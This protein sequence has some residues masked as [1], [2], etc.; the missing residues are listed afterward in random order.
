[1]MSRQ[2]ISCT[3]KISCPIIANSSFTHGKWL[4][5][6]LWCWRQ[7]QF[8]Y[9]L[10]YDY[11]RGGGVQGYC[12]MLYFGPHGSACVLQSSIV[13]HLAY[14]VLDTSLLFVLSI[15]LYNFLQSMVLSWISHMS[16]TFWQIPTQSE[17][18]PSVHHYF[19]IF[20]FHTFWLN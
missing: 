15:V 1:M 8:I 10:M 13:L 2:I 12:G 18:L 6:G 7:V 14:F 19:K 9:K 17:I 16:H 3:T 20:R 5:P 11:L 4:S